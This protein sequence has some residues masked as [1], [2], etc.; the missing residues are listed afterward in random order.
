M[1][2]TNHQLFSHAYLSRLQADPANDATAAL[3]VQ[4]L[5]DWLPFR[6]TSS[7][8]ALFSSWIGPVLDFLGFHHAPNENAPQFHLL[9]A[10]R[11][12]EAP[13]GLCYVVPLGQDLDETTKGR[14]PMAQAVLALRARG[15]RWGML[16]DGVRWR[17]VD[18]QALQR[19][20]QYLEADLDE[21]ARSGDPVALRLLHAFFHC[22]AFTPTQLSSSKESKET[23]G[24][25]ALTTAST[26][27][28]KAVED[29]LKARVSHN[30][31]IMA[32]FCLGLVR[33]DGRDRYAEAE[34]DAIYR[35][36]TYL[37]YR[38]LFV[39]H[40]EAR[41]LL[42]MDNP[43]YQA[44]SLS[45][46]IQTSYA[47]QRQGMP[48]PQATTLWKR[49]KALCAAIY[50][51][52]PALGIP[53]YNGGLFD[54]ADKPYLRDGQIADAYLTP[55]LFDLAYM[56][57]SHSPDGYRAI[58]YRDLSVRH[59]GSLY[60][61][62]IEYRLQIAEETLWARRDGKGNVLFLRTGQDGTPRKTDVEIEPGQVYF[63]QS[64]G[65]RRATG[66]YYT[67]EYVVDYIVHQTVIHGL[68]ERRASLE[69]KLASWL[70]EIVAATGP[71]E[72]RQMQRTADEE[73][74]RF[75]EEQVLTF[76]T[77][78]MGMGS[79]HFLVNTA[80][81]MTAFVVETLH[82]TPWENPAIDTDPVVW[83]RRIVEH[84]LYGVDL[85]LMA[86]ELAKL[87]LWLASVARDKPLSFLD[88]HLRQGNSLIGAR[89]EDLAAALAAPA[90]PSRRELRER[91]A[92][93]LSM[94]D[95]PSFRQHVA[96]ATDLL[97]RI[98]A[99]VSDRLEDVKV[100]EVDYEQVRAE[101]EPYRRLGDL[102]VARHFGLDADEQQVRSL[103]RSLVNGAVSLLPEHQRVLAQAQ[104]LAKEYHFFHWAL[105]FPEVFLHQHGRWMDGITGFDGVMGNPPYVRQEALA[106]LKQYLRM[107][108]ASFHSAADLYVYFYEQGL[109]L[110]DCSGRMAYITSGTF[111]RANFAVPLRKWIPS[112]AQIET[113][114]DFGENQP[115][116][117]AEMV[118]PSIVVF[119]RGRQMSPFRTL[120]IA[121][122]R[123]PSS[124]HK[125][126]AQFGFECSPEILDQPE[127]IF[128]SATITD[129][130]AK[131]LAAG[132]P[133]GDVV[134]NEMYYGIKTGLNEAFI[135]DTATR[136]RLIQSDSKCEKLIR[137]MVRGADLRPWYQRG[138]SGWMVVLPSGWT[139]NSFGNA[140]GEAEAWSRFSQHYP[141]LA[142]H[143][144][145]FADTARRRH[146][147]GEF[148]WELR[149]C[150]YYGIFDKP[151]VLYP[152]ISKLP[153]FSLDNEG[154][155]INNS[156]FVIATQNRAILGILQSR[157]LWFAVSQ[158]CQPLRLR[159]GLWQYMLFTQFIGR[160]PIP[161]M[162]SAEQEC[163]GGL[164]E[165]IT[166]KA[167]ARHK[168]HSRIHLHILSE[169]GMPGTELNNKL[170]RWWDLGFL[171]FCIQVQKVLR[172]EIPERE[173]DSW[174]AWL[175]TQRVEH[176]RLTAEIVHLETGLNE[177]VY[178]L[179]NLT[180]QEVQTIEQSTEYRY[181]EV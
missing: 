102:L 151:K 89:L 160:L 158:I 16:T 175:A 157:V 173:R 125:A 17:L 123:I 108:F 49:L 116:D 172:H 170:A 174:N 80:H 46:L 164:A 18:A 96:T 162:S 67:P 115:F 111:A 178:R 59:L 45:T 74:L 150:D 52:D 107:R 36:A 110:L 10:H 104:E 72:R 85:N 53:A 5:R 176:E 63:S 37:L 4:G 109:R 161:D 156:G 22:N 168:L 153:R 6:D 14:H 32:Q 133:L 93:Q 20:E 19:Y 119:K 60:E 33:A 141:S 64:P 62:M 88:H 97:A 118:R 155:F 86:V 159:G 103:A 27:A 65:E 113:V 44:A 98:A 68:G 7:P 29:H 70:Q 42:P 106:R 165:A 90:A 148:W 34:R 122:T 54:D 43:S 130:F 154:K 181:G 76:R 2:V 131:V 99:R 134:R 21:L 40:A 50:D 38:I 79:G 105:E 1:I 120:F 147:K 87:S 114:I 146:D 126:L 143:F 152:E 100:Q 128:R 145:P 81:Q 135:I 8:A 51:S 95:D 117:E 61:G 39:L 24:L 78:D 3:I 71:D 23:A 124:L 144:Q 9:Y 137:Q 13:V 57:D 25:D 55:A 58:D 41:S 31:G 180:P 169:L 94:L 121:G 140:L 30:E 91:A 12:D 129:L 15:L 179:F 163:I 127:W 73:L 177:R 149:A 77:C 66:T 92:G 84:C 136:D 35:D 166:E 132:V 101:L 75:V 142:K 26:K 56:P 48:D 47:Y 28:T 82:L 112:N 11:G 139:R 171:D 167:R 138:G 69:A 83:R